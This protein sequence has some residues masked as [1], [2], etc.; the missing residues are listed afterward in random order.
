MN[1]LMINGSPHVNGNTFLVLETIAT[2]LK[3]CGVDSEIVHIGKVGV[4]GCNACMKCVETG[5][6]TDQDDLVNDCID[7][8]KAADG[9]IVGSPVYFAGPNA[10]LCGFLDRLFYQKADPYA[11]KPAAAITVSRRGGN[12]AAFDRLNKYFTFAQMPIVSANYWNEAHGGSEGE[13]EQDVEGLQTMRVLAR[14]MAWLLKCIECSK[15]K[16]ELPKIE[17]R[18]KYSFIRD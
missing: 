18:Q 10:S 9:F 5:Y 13:V 4:R 12:S 17:P 16:V 8:L 1:V 14:N 11:F 2:E 7:K 15:G 6:C 3:L